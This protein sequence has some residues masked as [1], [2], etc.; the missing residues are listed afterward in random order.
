MELSENT[1]I[2]K[3]AIELVKSK[4]SSYD[5]IY[6]FGLVELKSLKTYIKTHL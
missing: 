6:A 4:Q 5:S 2:N 3:H 1:G